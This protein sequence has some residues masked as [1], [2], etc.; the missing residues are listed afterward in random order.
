[1][2][3]ISCGQILKAKK[4]SMTTT[5]RRLPFFFNRSLDF[6]NAMKRD[7]ETSMACDAEDCGIQMLKDD[8]IVNCDSVQE[9]SIPVNDETDED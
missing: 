5:G 2:H 7:V 8:E 9:E 1:M 4:T 6:K 3:G